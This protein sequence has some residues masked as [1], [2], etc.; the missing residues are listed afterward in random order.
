MAHDEAVKFEAESLG[1]GMLPDGWSADVDVTGIVT[2][3]GPCPTCG[4]DAWG[5]PLPTP[6]SAVTAESL[7]VANRPESQPH[8]QLR[9]VRAECHCGFEHGNDGADGCGRWWMVNVRL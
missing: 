4:G 9:R 3:S 7:V 6:E 1:S 8:D 2:V 5:P